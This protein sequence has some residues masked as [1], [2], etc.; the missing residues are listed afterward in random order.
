MTKTAV[1]APDQFTLMPWKN[2]KGETTELYCRRAPGSD[3]FEWRLSIASVTEDGLFSNFSGYHRT[4][5]MIAGQGLELRHDG[6]ATQL[7]EYRY[8]F[9]SFAGDWQTTARLMHGP[10][11]DFN[12]ICNTQ[13]CWSKVSVIQ[14]HEQTE[15]ESEAGDLL[16]YADKSDGSYSLLATAESARIPKGYL[17]HVSNRDA[18]NMKVSG[19]GLICIEIFGR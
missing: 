6:Q 14:R 18:T 17:V 3:E 8:D 7:L 11:K 9:C 15:I 10:I 12:I 2:G 4:L 19:D 5:I 13:H 16:I 1:I